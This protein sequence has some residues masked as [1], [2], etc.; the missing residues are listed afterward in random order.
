MRYYFHTRERERLTKDAAG[1]DLPDDE[2]AVEV[3]L[4]AARDRL[5]AGSRSPE[6]LDDEVIEVLDEAQELVAMIP[7]KFMAAGM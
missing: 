4:N 5:A 1:L 6:S 7:V 2:N 3:G